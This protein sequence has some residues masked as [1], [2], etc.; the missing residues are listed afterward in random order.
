MTYPRF[1]TTEK[2]LDCIMQKYRFAASRALLETVVTNWSPEFDEYFNKFLLSLKLDAAVLERLQGTI[3]RSGYHLS[4]RH[5]MMRT[6]RSAPTPILPPSSIDAK[7]LKFEHIHETE[8][9]RQL[10]MIANEKMSKIKS[11]DI[12]EY[13]GGR[14]SEVMGTALEHNQKLATWVTEEIKSSKQQRSTAKKFVEVIKQ[15]VELHNYQDASTI[16]AT[17]KQIKAADR[18]ELVML[19]TSLPFKENADIPKLLVSPSVPPLEVYLAHIKQIDDLESTFTKSGLI[20]WPKITKLADATKEFL[21][22]SMSS[23]GEDDITSVSRLQNWIHLKVFGHQPP[24]LEPLVYG[25]SGVKP[26]PYTHIS[27]QPT[28]KL[29][30][31]KV[32]PPKKKT[33]KGVFSDLW[34]GKTKN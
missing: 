9:A 26:T 31:Q 23:Y 10:T 13:L 6:A 2:F 30:P 16:L 1:T 20:R 12:M 25:R 34:R 32:E 3:Q 18:R 19:E 29:I 21:D 5:F 28:P 15:L 4:T 24:V 7:H 33:V 17:L 27:V 14:T 8:F 11:K 22:S